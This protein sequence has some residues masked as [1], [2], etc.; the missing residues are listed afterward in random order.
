M[1]NPIQQ[2]RPIHD[3]IAALAYQI[4]ERKGRTIG[5]ELESW[6]EAEQQLLVACFHPPARSAIKG[7]RCA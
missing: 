5:Q 4:W 3:D 6:L 1:Q 2:V 7:S